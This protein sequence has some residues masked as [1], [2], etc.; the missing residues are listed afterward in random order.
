MCYFDNSILSELQLVTWFHK[1]K[2]Y[3]NQ[4]QTMASEQMNCV[5]QANYLLNHYA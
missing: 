3:V 1:R 4:L 2:L 5:L